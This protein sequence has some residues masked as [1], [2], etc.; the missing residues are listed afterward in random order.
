[1]DGPLGNPQW[2]VKAHVR[3]ASE[4]RTDLHPAARESLPGRLDAIEDWAR[5]SGIPE[6]LLNAQASAR[7]QA[8]TVAGVRLRSEA[9]HGRDR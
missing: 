6:R 3:A 7:S 4:R 2:I 5:E 1:V 9:R 8:R